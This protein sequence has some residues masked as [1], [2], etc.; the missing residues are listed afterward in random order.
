[1]NGLK[2]TWANLSYRDVQKEL[3]AIRSTDKYDDAQKPASVFKAP[4][5]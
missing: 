3:T 4:E 2:T 1:M 5:K